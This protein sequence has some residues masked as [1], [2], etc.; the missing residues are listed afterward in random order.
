MPGSVERLGGPF[1][2]RVAR[3]EPDLRYS[4]DEVAAAYGLDMPPEPRRR[5]PP[6]PERAVGSHLTRIDE[7]DL[8]IEPLPGI[9]GGHRVICPW[10]HEHTDQDETGTVYFEPSAE[11]GWRGGFKCHHGHC[12]NRGIKEFDRFIRAIGRIQSL[13]GRAA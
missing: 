6:P 1:V 5:P 9:E 12:M 2:Q 4:I 3:W 7:L 10:V 11:N 13:K 8:Y